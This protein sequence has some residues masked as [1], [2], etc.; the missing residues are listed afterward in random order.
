MSATGGMA[1]ESK[2]FYSRLSGMVSEKRNQPYPIVTAWVNRKLSFSLIRSVGLCLRGSRSVKL[3]ML[4]DSM[5]REAT[6][7]EVICRINNPV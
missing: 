2:T 7:G 5:E 3:S 4:V 6:S 1:R